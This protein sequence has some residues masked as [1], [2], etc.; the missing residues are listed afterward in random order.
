[1]RVPPQL[2]R[3]IAEKGSV[4][5]DGTSLTVNAVTRDTLSVLLIP[6]TLQVT[7]WGGI[8]AGSRVNVEIDLMARYAARLAEAA[9][10]Q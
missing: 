4:S 2:S 8:R 7:T 3:F 9:H 5:L 1:V 10:W 6:H